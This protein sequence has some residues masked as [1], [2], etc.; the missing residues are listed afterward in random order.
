ME[1]ATQKK[2]GRNQQP[3]LFPAD[4]FSFS[5]FIL[6]LLVAKISMILAKSQYIETE[7]NVIENRRKS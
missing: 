6:V 1:E 3:A 4:I 5:Q 7:E 2:V